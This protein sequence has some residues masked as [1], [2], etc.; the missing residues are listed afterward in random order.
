M[1]FLAPALLLSLAGCPTASGPAVVEQELL[2]EAP[3]ASLF[4]GY[5]GRVLLRSE[6]PARFSVVAGA[7]PS[8]LAMDEAGRITGTPDWLGTFEA[9]V[10]AEPAD[11]PDLEGPLEI[12]VAPGAT[13]VA[14]GFPREPKLAPGDT[15]LLGDLWVRIAGAGEPGMDRRPF[16]PGLYTAG[17]DGVFDGGGGDDVRVGDLSLD[18]EAFL[19]LGQWNPSNGEAEDDPPTLLDGVLV[20]GEQAG[21]RSLSFSAESYPAQPVTLA[22]VPPDWCPLGDHPGGGPNPGVCE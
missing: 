7:L 19:G 4:A 20:A 13:E 9:T 11:G 14:P 2:I 21:E 15:V 8:G 10:R 12:T 6:A 22:V 1:R 16:E 5:S 3:E 18:G 17:P